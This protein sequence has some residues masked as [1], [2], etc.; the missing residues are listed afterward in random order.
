MYAS[1]SIRELF[2]TTN[3]RFNLKQDGDVCDLSQFIVEK[4]N[5]ISIYHLVIKISW[6]NFFWNKIINNMICLGQTPKKLY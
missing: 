1:E 6:I 3:F 2:Q 5:Y 4:S